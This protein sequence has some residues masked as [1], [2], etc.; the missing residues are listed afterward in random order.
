M[1]LIFYFRAYIY[2]E[3]NIFC[4][5]PY[6]NNY[7]ES[8]FIQLN[9]N[10][11]KTIATSKKHKMEI[12]G[13]VITTDN[14][15]SIGRKKKRYIKS[16]VFKYINKSITAEEYTYLKGYLSFVQSVEVGFLHN[17]RD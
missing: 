12:T 14:K 2:R 5:L 13:L 15:I 6:L 11:D 17:K 9:I 10:H 3:S 8:F 1:R 4:F 16:L 7:L